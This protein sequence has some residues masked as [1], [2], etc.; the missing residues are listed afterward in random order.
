[1]GKFFSYIT[2]ER[3]ELAYALTTGA[4]QAGRSFDAFKK[5]L[6]EG[7]YVIRSQQS[8]K[9]DNETTEVRISVA[10]AGKGDSSAYLSSGPQGETRNYSF[11]VKKENGSWKIDSYR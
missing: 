9:I 4:F 7:T 8:T 10:V 6:P 2:S 3:Y 5:Q 11:T 1:M